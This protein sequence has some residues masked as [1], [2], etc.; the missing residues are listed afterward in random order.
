MKVNMEENPLIEKIKDLLSPLLADTDMFLTQ[1]RIKPVN[2]IKLFLDAD[3]GMSISKCAQINRSLYAAIESE[4]MFPE[5][6]YSLEVSS[7]GVDEPLQGLRQYQK[8]IGR[9]LEV[10]PVEGKPVTGT[11][12]AVDEAQ[13]TLEVTD[14][15]KKETNEVILPFDTVKKAVVQIVFK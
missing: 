14:K 6:D 10:E 15:K 13:L 5:G 12:K 11:L 8:N 9:L 7:P 2:N 3:S 4:G 1:I